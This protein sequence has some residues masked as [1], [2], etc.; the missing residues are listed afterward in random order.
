[1]T[2]LQVCGSL[3]MLTAWVL[4]QEKKQG[5]R[6][7]EGKIKRKGQDRTGHAK[8]SKRLTGGIWGYGDV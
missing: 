8:E 1:M 3:M 5:T 7:N 2:T 6:E 4:M